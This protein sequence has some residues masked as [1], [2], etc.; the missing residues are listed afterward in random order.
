LYGGLT[1]SK[2]ILVIQAL[3]AFIAMVLVG[4]A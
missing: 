2:K 3:P 1:A 4:L